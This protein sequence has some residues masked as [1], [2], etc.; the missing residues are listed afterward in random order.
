MHFPMYTVGV[1]RLFEMT[2]IEPHEE[3]KAG[4]R[5]AIR[6]Q[7]AQLVKR[8]VIVSKAV[9]VYDLNPRST[10]IEPRRPP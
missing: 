9:A 1:D 5:S 2:K 4:R 7:D 10:I 3:L 8:T 6:A